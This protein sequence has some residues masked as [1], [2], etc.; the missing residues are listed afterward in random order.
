MTSKVNAKMFWSGTNPNSVVFIKK[1]MKTNQFIVVETQ[2]I[3]IQ[4]I[5]EFIIEPI[6]HKC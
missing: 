2:G 4:S 1:S 6:V 3:I 5:I